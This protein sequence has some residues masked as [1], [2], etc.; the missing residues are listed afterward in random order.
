MQA[1]EKP[2]I[3]VFEAA[4]PAQFG[5]V[6][7][8]RKKRPKAISLKS[9]G[10]VRREMQRV[11]SDT[12]QGR[13]ESQEGARLTY[14]LSQVGKVLEIEVIEQRLLRLEG[15]ANVEK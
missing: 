9:L 2:E 1:T 8:L 12:R 10:A 13:I 6:V 14:I 4:T 7:P 5:V 3:E 11:Y 15:R